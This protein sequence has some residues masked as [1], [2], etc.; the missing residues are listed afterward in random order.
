[1][2]VTVLLLIAGLVLVLLGANY[3][4]DGASTIAK[5]FGLSDMIIGMTIVAIGTSAPEMVVSFIAAA[6]GNA[7]IAVGNVVGSNICNILLILGISSV[8]RPLKVTTDNLAKDIPFMI[9][10]TT[11]L[12]AMAFDA[13]INEKAFITE[14][15]NNHINRTDGIILLLFFAVFLFYSFF[16]AK[17]NAITSATSVM[18]EEGDIDAKKVHIKSVDSKSAGS[19]D[20]DSVKEGKK[21]GKFNILGICKTSL[22]LSVLGV[23]GGLAMLIYGGDLFIDNA[24]LLASS[25]GVSDVIIAATVVAIGTSLPE[26]AT[27]IVAAAKNNLGLA[28]G[29]VVG[30]NIFNIFLILG[31]SAVITPLSL[32]NVHFNHFV[33]LT[34][35]SILLLFFC[36]TK[37]KLQRVEGIIFL[38]IYVTYIVDTIN[39]G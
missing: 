26:L 33:V 6:Q 31:G 21:A 10:S 16:S 19:N 9:L 37:K 23:F 2:G 24:K 38:L 14:F 8:I 13:Q 15:T 12:V 20:S 25:L 35:S 11:A 30:S 17:Q 27:S 18:P 32:Q 28:L 34:L 22:L 1:M 36:G 4:V 5:R 3:L 7:D 29:N 39:N